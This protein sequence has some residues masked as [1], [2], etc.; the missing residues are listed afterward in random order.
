MPNVNFETM[1]LVDL[2]PMK[3]KVLEQ[4]TAQYYNNGELSLPSGTG[5]TTQELYVL[6]LKIDMTVKSD[7]I[8]KLSYNKGSLGMNMSVTQKKKEKRVYTPDIFT[9]SHSESDKE[10][11]DF[12][13]FSNLNI[14][15]DEKMIAVFINNEYIHS[16]YWH[17]NSITNF[18]GSPITVSGSKVVV[19]SMKVSNEPLAPEMTKIALQNI[20]TYQFANVA[21]KLKQQKNDKSTFEDIASSLLNGKKLTDTLD[22]N[23]FLKENKLSLRLG[24]NNSWV[25]R[26]S[27]KNVCYV[28]IFGDTTD[29]CINPAF[30]L[31]DH[32][33]DEYEK[34]I[35]DKNMQNLVLSG[36][37]SRRCRP[38]CGLRD[39]SLFGKIFDLM[40]RCHTIEIHNPNTA[41]LE[42]LKKLVLIIKQMNIDY[43]KAKKLEYDKCILGRA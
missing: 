39:K 18:V 28:K 3:P 41:Q 17:K 20:I 30:N 31:Y 24:S 33:F 23:S 38:H 27:G 16:S 2:G 42:I 4:T 43:A 35:T 21:Q 9:G 19:K 6:P 13:E 1:T 12:S 10:K 8:L 26:S 25:A 11:L 15:M 22:F 14:Y 5:A 37:A 36:V 32:N 34:Q 7:K 29:W 40:C